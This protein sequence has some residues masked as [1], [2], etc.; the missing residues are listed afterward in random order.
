MLF[1]NFFL[2]HFWVLHFLSHN[3]TS[4]FLLKSFFLFFKSSILTLINVYWLIRGY[5]ILLCLFVLKKNFNTTFFLQILEE[6]VQYVK[7]IFCLNKVLTFSLIYNY[8]DVISLETNRTSKK[9]LGKVII[10]LN[11][12]RKGVH[13]ISS[14]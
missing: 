2:L 13:K 1:F 4:T 7:I 14:M 11:L 6:H 10:S 12:F 9:V 5:F 8:L 3:V